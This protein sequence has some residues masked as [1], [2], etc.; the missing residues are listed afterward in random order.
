MANT[1]T[2]KAGIGFG[3]GQLGGS[4]VIEILI[5]HDTIPALSGVRIGF[6]LLNGITLQQ[7][8]RILEVLNENVIGVFTT[9]ASDEKTEAA[10]G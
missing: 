3:V 8:K 9:T 4:T 7:A 6:E 10:A 5:H 1:K 2:Q